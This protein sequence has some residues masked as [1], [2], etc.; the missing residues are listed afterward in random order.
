MRL[1]AKQYKAVQKYADARGLKMALSCA[2]TMY[3]VSKS[4]GE[5]VT[6]QLDRIVALYENRQKDIA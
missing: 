3:F 1:T 4:T 2:P 6:E 5:K